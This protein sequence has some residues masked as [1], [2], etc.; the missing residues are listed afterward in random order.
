MTT[1]ASEAQRSW[2]DGSS[3]IPKRSCRAC[4]AL[5]FTGVGLAEHTRLGCGNG[6]GSPVKRRRAWPTAAQAANW[7]AAGR[8]VVALNNSR[9][10]RCTE[11]GKL[12]TPSGIALHQRKFNHSGKVEEGQ[13]HGDS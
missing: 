1:T 13:H 4:G 7:S 10:V 2:N 3:V 11:C 5:F 8:R 6:H 9:R 12:S